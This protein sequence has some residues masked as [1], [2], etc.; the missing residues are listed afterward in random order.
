MNF[1]QKKHTSRGDGS[2]REHRCG[3]QATG[4]LSTHRPAAARASAR[5]AHSTLA[6]WLKRWT[7]AAAVCTDSQS[8]QWM[9]SP[10][11]TSYILPSCRHLPAALTAAG[12]EVPWGQEVR[13]TWG[14]CP[15]G[16]R[17]ADWLVAQG[18]TG[19]MVGMLLG[20]AAVQ[21]AGCKAWTRQLWLAAAAALTRFTAVLLHVFKGHDLYMVEA[22]GRESAAVHSASAKANYQ[23]QRWCPH[24]TCPTQ[25]EPPLHR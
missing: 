15:A 11:C 21:K 2:E 6:R 1:L 3:Q 16:R 20:K 17:S 5:Q 12:K 19:V 24:V 22:G 14:G 10:S 4:V 18:S 23:V 8:H 13:R 9:I 7:Q 25:C